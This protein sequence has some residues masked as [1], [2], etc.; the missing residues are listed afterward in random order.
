M[1]FGSLLWIP[2]LMNFYVFCIT[3]SSIDSAL[4]CHRSWNDFGIIFDVWE[5]PFSFAHATSKT[6]K[7]FCFYD[8]F[9]C[10]YTSEKKMLMNS[11]IHL[12]TSFGIGCWWVLASILAP[13][14]H[15]FGIQ[16]R[17][18]GD[19]FFNDLL[20]GFVMENGSWNSPG[21]LC[22]SM[23]FTTFSRILLFL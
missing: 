12:A 20:D 7:C 18:F 21:N 19:R 17:V 1:F 3:F 16:I 2:L 10:C 23:F 5:I 15:S 22:A 6:F 13:F 4:I 9:T 14:W 8:E 11:M